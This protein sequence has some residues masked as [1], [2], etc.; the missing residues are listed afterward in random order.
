MALSPYRPLD[1]WLV[2]RLFFVL[3]VAFGGF[4][5]FRVYIWSKAW[6]RWLPIV[7]GHVLNWGEVTGAVVLVAFFLF[8]YYLMFLNHRSTDF[9]VEIEGELRKVSWPEYKPIGSMKAELWGSTYVVIGVVIVMAIYIGLVDSIYN[10]IATT[11][12]YR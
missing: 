7:S 5:A 12:F 1:G 3:M 9:L 8:A 11:L 4:S 6:T 10:F 2:R